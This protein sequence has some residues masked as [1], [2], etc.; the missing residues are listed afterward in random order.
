M[1]NAI[2]SALGG[3]LI[4]ATHC[5]APYV[6]F[7]TVDLYEV[8]NPNGRPGFA[9]VF[10]PWAWRSLTHQRIP[11]NAPIQDGAEQRVRAAINRGMKNL[12]DGCPDRWLVKAITTDGDGW[13]AITG[14]CASQ[15][16][17]GTDE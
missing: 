5:A 2:A 16:E 9:A 12:G 3:V 1:R 15:V 4:F 8:H 7:A 10:S 6:N 14:Y 13:V 17:L 11:S